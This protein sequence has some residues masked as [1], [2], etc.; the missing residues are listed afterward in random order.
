MYN[1]NRDAELPTI[2]E[3]DQS[4]TQLNEDIVFQAGD[5]PRVIVNPNGL[6]K[7]ISNRDGTV[8]PVHMEFVRYV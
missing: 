2:F 7:A 6:I 1:T 8:T 5:S 4:T 3:I